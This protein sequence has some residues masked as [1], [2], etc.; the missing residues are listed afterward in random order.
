MEDLDLQETLLLHDML[1]FFHEH[2]VHMH[3]KKW[4]YVAYH[5]DSD[6]EFD[7]RMSQSCML[8]LASNGRR[9]VITVC[10]PKKIGQARAGQQMNHWET[11]LDL[12][13]GDIWNAYDEDDGIVHSD[14]I[15]Q[16][17]AKRYPTSV[18]HIM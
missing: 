9:Q 3:G 1:I 18:S 14:S 6:D 10:L 4:K 13:L 5:N 12:D 17:P 11:N 7:I 16:T 2:S 15:V 8:S